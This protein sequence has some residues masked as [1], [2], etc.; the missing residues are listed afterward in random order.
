MATNSFNSESSYT[1]NDTV[2]RAQGNL[3]PCLIILGGEKLSPLI[4]PLPLASIEFTSITFSNGS[5]TIS[6]NTGTLKM[7]QNPAGLPAPG[8]DFTYTLSGNTIIFTAPFLGSSVTGIISGNQLSLIVDGETRIFNKYAS[9]AGNTNAPFIIGTDWTR[10][11]S[12]EGYEFVD[13]IRF[14]T[15]TTGIMFTMPTDNIE[16]F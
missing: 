8:R 11:Y 7:A 15:D 13:T 16:L 1:G 4:D 9:P 10:T 5:A 6:A 14:F 12:E 2:T 3:D